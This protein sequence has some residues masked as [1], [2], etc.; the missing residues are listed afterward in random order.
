MKIC[1]DRPIIMTSLTIDHDSV[2]I[3][4]L[5]YNSGTDVE[6]GAN[7]VVFQRIL[8]RCTT[9][10][11]IDNSISDGTRSSQIVISEGSGSTV[12]IEV[13]P[14]RIPLTILDNDGKCQCFIVT[15]I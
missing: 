12:P 13:Y 3:L 4:T 5:F 11:T 15:Q 9:I 10:S 1:V 2:K 7:Q 6:L 14:S 8:M